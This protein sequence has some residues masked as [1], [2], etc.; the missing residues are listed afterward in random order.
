MCNAAL[1]DMAQLA[2]GTVGQAQQY[3]AMRSSALASERGQFA[4]MQ[5]REKQIDEQATDEMAERAKQAMADAGRVNA[6]FAATNLSGNS[7]ERMSRIAQ[8]SASADQ[9]TLERNRD[10]QI[11]QA[12]AEAA[13]IAARTVS[14]INSVRRPSFIGAGLQIAAIGT[15]EYDRTH[16]KPSPSLSIQDFGGEDFG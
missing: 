1:F 10:A 11:T 16:P 14:T 15:N 9:T 4:Q 3:Q 8:G 13:G 7:Q 5:D 6:I 2:I 12:Q